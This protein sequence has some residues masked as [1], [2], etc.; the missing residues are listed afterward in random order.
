MY[1]ERLD[2]SFWNTSKARLLDTKEILNKLVSLTGS[3]EPSEQGSNE[4]LQD[5]MLELLLAELATDKGVK[6][7][8]LLT[9]LGAA[10]GFACQMII[11]E[12]MIAKGVV[13]EE[14]AFVTIDTTDNNTYYSG[15]L[16][17]EGLAEPK[18][19]NLSVWSLVGGAPNH[20]G[21]EVPDIVDIFRHTS[22]TMGSPEYGRPRVPAGNQPEE[23][24]EVLLAKYWNVLRNLQ[25]TYRGSVGTMHLMTAQLAQRVIIN[26]QNV[27][28]PTLAAQVV[29]EAAVP[30]SKMSPDRVPYAYFKTYK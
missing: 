2:A 23:R 9:T 18:P 28:D 12:E 3:E 19:G 20:L 5:A 14:D 10:A 1:E 26:N 27:I 13:S 8:T 30:M 6:I 21:K 11:R 24:A 29:M 7:E 15:D 4:D 25:V 17:N 16:L 22:A